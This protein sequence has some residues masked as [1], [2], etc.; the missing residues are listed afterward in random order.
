MDQNELSKAMT[1][2][3]CVLPQFRSV[4]QSCPTLCNP[5]DCNTRP[6]CPSPTP[7]ACANS[8]PSSRCHPYQAINTL[9]FLPAEK[10]EHPLLGPHSAQTTAHLPVPVRPAAPAASTP[11]RHATP[12]VNKAAEISPSREMVVLNSSFYFWPRP[13]ACRILVHQ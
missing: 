1:L 12:S 2:Q 8:C 6:P 9:F 10:Q 11:A 5:M 7:G 3:F 4:T 13:V